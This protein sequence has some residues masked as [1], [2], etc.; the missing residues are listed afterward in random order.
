MSTE[1]NENNHS[2]NLNNKN[3]EEITEK[4][5]QSPVN[6]SESYQKRLNEF[7][8]PKKRYY[9]A[10]CDESLDM[11]KKEQIQGLTDIL[12]ELKKE[13]DNIKIQRLMDD[14]TRLEKKI[15]MIQEM[16]AKT[17]KKN[18]ESKF[19]N[20]NIKKAIEVTRG[21]LKEEEYKKKTLT[22][23][24]SK[25]KK[26]INLNEITL[27]K[28]YDKQN[29]LKQKLHRQKL[30][31]NEIKAKGNNIN[32]QIST[33]IQKNEIDQNEYSLQVQYYNTIIQQ[34][35]EFIRAADE[36]KERQIKIAQDAK[37]SSVDKEEK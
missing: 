24:L 25:I 30:L 18:E 1:T 2:S 21:R 4:S 13:H 22:A 19:V 23:V 29:I 3:L 32:S 35:L 33:Q 8:Q 9:L 37:K 17:E 20:E 10:S 7:A 5:R 12:I 27:Q 31:E 34:K 26:D 15:I 36:R 11:L 28:S 16:D 14:T 6:P